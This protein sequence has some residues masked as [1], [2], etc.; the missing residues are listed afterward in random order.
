MVIYVLLDRG[1]VFGLYLGMYIFIRV[2]Y[3][4]PKIDMNNNNNKKCN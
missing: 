3:R 4:N 1:L 2:K